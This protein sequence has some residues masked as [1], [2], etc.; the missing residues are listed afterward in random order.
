[1]T[2]Q[3]L[4]EEEYEETLTIPANGLSI[5]QLSLLGLTYHGISPRTDSPGLISLH[6]QLSDQHN[7]A[8][9]IGIP[10]CDPSR[11]HSPHQCQAWQTAPSTRF[12]SGISGSSV[13]FTEVPLHSVTP[14]CFHEPAFSCRVS[15]PNVLSALSSAP[16]NDF[17]S[18][19]TQNSLNVEDISPASLSSTSFYVP[20]ITIT[21]QSANQSSQT[22]VTSRRAWLALD[23]LVSLSSGHAIY[24]EPCDVDPSSIGSCVTFAA[25]PTASESC[26]SLS[27]RDRETEELAIGPIQLAAAL[28]EQCCLGLLGRRTQ[29]PPAQQLLFQQLTRPLQATKGVSVPE[30]SCAALQTAAIQP[31]SPVIS[32]SDI[33]TTH[34]NPSLSS[35]KSIPTQ[36]AVSMI[37]TAGNAALG[38]HSTHLDLSKS[39]QPLCTSATDINGQYRPF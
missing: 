38:S 25:E 26:N 3:N 30:S 29:L 36:P 6:S 5:D 1:M 21:T 16:L 10:G 32:T 34:L 23:N 13:P 2:L 24:H 12:D 39:A 8:V 28:K 15:T 7:C 20:S 19:T 35:A 17:R 33:T 31:D 22:T 27:Q 14:G 4:F 18:C 9:D 37:T 11:S